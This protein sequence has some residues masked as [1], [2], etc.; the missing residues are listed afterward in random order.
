MVVGAVLHL[1][2]GVPHPTPLLVLYGLVLGGL[3]AARM[4]VVQ[5]VTRE[6]R[7]RQE[8]MAEANRARQAAG[9]TEEPDAGT[10]GSAGP[11][12]SGGSPVP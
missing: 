6:T 3:F 2:L 7:E 4:K 1:G 11:S 9:S 5:D 8:A 12:L 10:D